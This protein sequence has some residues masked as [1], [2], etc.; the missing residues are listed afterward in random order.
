MCKQLTATGFGRLRL[1][2]Q[3]PHN[4]EVSTTKKAIHIVELFDSM[5]NHGAHTAHICNRHSWWVNRISPIPYFSNHTQI[6]ALICRSNCY[7][8]QRFQELAGILSLLIHQ[9]F[10]CMFRSLI[11]SVL[12]LFSLYLTNNRKF[13]WIDRV[14]LGQHTPIVRFIGWICYVH[15][16]WSFYHWYVGCCCGCCCQW[17]SFELNSLNNIQYSCPQWITLLG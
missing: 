5:F 4:S 9:M 8:T 6:W 13:V 14:F 2:K 12:L 16:K 7:C 10:V 17:N 3:P 1:P 15:C 11:V